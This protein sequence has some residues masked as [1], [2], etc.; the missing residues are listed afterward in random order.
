VTTGFGF[1][2]K[3]PRMKFKRSS[4]NRALLSA[5]ASISLLLG[6]G[7]HDKHGQPARQSSLENKATLRR[8]LGGEPGTLDP[9][10]AADSF[11]LEVLGDL[12]EG[13]T[14][15]SADGTVVPGVAAS[16]TV[17]PTGIRYEFHLPA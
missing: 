1:P 9:R 12:Y 6:A 3:V 13:L 14:T 16:W 15:E 8:G 10:A 2:Q 11:S 4:R 7:C 5:T 17:D